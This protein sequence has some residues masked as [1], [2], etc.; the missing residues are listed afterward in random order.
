MGVIDRVRLEPP[1]GVSV[2]PSPDTLD[3]IGSQV[4]RD[5]GTTALYELRDADGSFPS[6]LDIADRVGTPEEVALA[7]LDLRAQDGAIEQVGEVTL[8]LTAADVRHLGQARGN[9]RDGAAAVMDLP[10]VRTVLGVLRDAGHRFAAAAINPA[11]IESLLG[12]P[13]PELDGNTGN[14]PITL[15][16]QQEP[17]LATLSAQSTAHH[18]LVHGSGAVG[19]RA[20]SRDGPGEP[21]HDADATSPAAQAAMVVAGQR[22]RNEQIAR[23]EGVDV[24]RLY[25]VHRRALTTAA[26]EEA[27]AGLRSWACSSNWCPGRARTRARGTSRSR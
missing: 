25:Q 8:P 11:D 4:T 18:A 17:P 19:P 13:P 16:L 7:L 9:A 27:E 1:E 26:A 2:A 12:T 22:S 21:A 10:D 3:G 20:A 15:Y 14:H 24:T 23:A 5:D 6:S